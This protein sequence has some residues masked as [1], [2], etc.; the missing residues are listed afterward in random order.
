MAEDKGKVKFTKDSLIA[1]VLKQKPQTAGIFFELGM[2]CLGCVVALGESIEAAA[3]AHG[4]DMAELLKRV[5][6]A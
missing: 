1:D 5:N 3:Q 2:P 4:I 6:E